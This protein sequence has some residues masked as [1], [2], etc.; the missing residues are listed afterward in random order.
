MRSAVLL[1]AGAGF[2]IDAVTCVDDHRSWSATE[3]SSAYRMVLVRRGRFRRMTDGLPA[4]LDPTIAYLGI[5]GEEERFAHP[6]GG[7]LCTSIAVTPTLWHTLLTPPPTTPAR[8]STTPAR[9]TRP[10]T[11]HPPAH[12]ST[13]PDAE[14]PQD[15]TVPLR[16]STSAPP[17][18]TSTQPDA[19]PRQGPAVPLR[20]ST[21]APPL[22]TSPGHVTADTRAALTDTRAAVIDTRPALADA[23]PAAEF[24]RGLASPRPRSVRSPSERASASP[25]P[26][27]SGHSPAD[28]PATP[29]S[30]PPDADSQVLVSPPSAPATTSPAPANASPDADSHALPSPPPAP[31]TSSPAPASAPCDSSAVVRDHV[32]VSVDSPGA[33]RESGGGER[34]ASSDATRPPRERGPVGGRRHGTGAV[35]STFYVDARVD[36]AHRRVLVAGRTG[37]VAY[38]LTE[39]LL[40][41][42]TAAL[43]MRPES[44]S[45]SAKP[46][47]D[48][49]REAI[50]SGDPAAEGLLPLAECLDVSPYQ[51]SRA[52]TRELG[53]SL[54]H[55][56]NRVRVG[57]ALDRL[58]A[59][60][61]SLAVLAADLGFADQ[62]H[63]TRTIRQHVGHTPTTLRRLLTPEGAPDA[64]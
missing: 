32:V 3:V 17:A 22:P 64:P 14:P 49:A 35:P 18:H 9:P 54:T 52:F 15:P 27:A 38:A 24:G 59:G 62:A 16:D 25:L 34:S 57:A 51:L 7:D 19:K 53:V 33:G 28:S 13:Q 56:R 31:A 1:A 12:T 44:S 23:S 36:L 30:A 40:T 60:E 63:L 5:P 61:P 2:T 4:D 43:A 26:T 37:D 10:S 47:V 39:S 41:L 58:E 8:P 6:T 50:A 11:T 42:M 48:A 20:D 55:Y 29:A 21:S 46:I 45:R